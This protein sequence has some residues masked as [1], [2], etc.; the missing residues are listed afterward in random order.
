MEQQIRESR[1]QAMKDLLELISSLDDQVDYEREVPHGN[2]P[3]ELVCMW[4]D[5]QYFGD[6]PWFHEWYSKREREVLAVFNALYNDKKEALPMDGGV[7]ALHATP[8]WHEVV[9]AARRA[10]VGMRWAT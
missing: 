3:S 1:R 10:L 7:A 4:F 5:D 9:A 2:V 6:Q 8:E